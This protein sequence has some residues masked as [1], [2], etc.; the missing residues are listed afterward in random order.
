MEPSRFRRLIDSV[1]GVGFIQDG[2]VKFAAIVMPDT[3]PVRYAVD[4][5]PG[6]GF[7]ILSDEVDVP[8]VGIVATFERGGL[9]GIGFIQTLTGN[10]VAAIAWPQGDPKRFLVIDLE[11]VGVKIIDRMD[12]PSMPPT[13][14]PTDDLRETSDSV[15]STPVASTPVSEVTPNVAATS[16]PA[17]SQPTPPPASEVSTPP[18]APEAAADVTSTATTPT[19]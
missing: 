11:G 8:V 15:A 10:E 2:P 13:E 7:E 6:Y 17:A 9:E 16:P 3:E 19:A 1:I 12:P 5:L 18:A 14:S 4:D